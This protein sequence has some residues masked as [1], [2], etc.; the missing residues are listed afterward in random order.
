LADALIFLGLPYDSEMA[1]RLASRI[2]E[3]IRNAAYDA[4][5]RLAEEKGAFKAFSPE[6][7]LESPFVRRLP[8][9]LRARIARSGLRNSHLLAIAPAGS[10][11]LLA[12]NV[13]S[14][15]EPVFSAYQ[16]RQFRTVDGR[17]AAFGLT[18]HALDIWVQSGLRAGL[19][20]ALVTAADLSSGANLKMQ[21]AIQPF[22]DNAI[23]KTINILRADGNDACDIFLR[24][25]DL[26]L[27]GC[28]VFRTHGCVRGVIVPAG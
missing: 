19:P 8:N 18:D 13:S 2:A 12:G 17:L 25:F 6:H 3:T 23:S 5:I 4:S 24:A 10:I 15:I 26:G 28:T 9:G 27:K 14:G 22:I 21:A 20:P 7:Y 1:C 16:V 11:S